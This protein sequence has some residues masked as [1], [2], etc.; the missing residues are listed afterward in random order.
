LSEDAHFPAVQAG[1]FTAMSLLPAVPGVP[2]LRQFQADQG[3]VARAWL[4]RLAGLN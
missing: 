2:T 3:A 4:G 1:F